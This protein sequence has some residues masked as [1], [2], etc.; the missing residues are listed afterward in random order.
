MTCKHV[1]GLLDAGP[2]ADYPGG[3]LDAAWRH[4]RHCGRCGRA[5]MAATRL[6]ADLAALP[7]PTPP[8][9]LTAAVLAR[10]AQSAAPHSD[11][12]ATAMT[13]PRSNRSDWPAGITAIGALAGGVA[14]LLSIDANSA[15]LGILS[16]TVGR[17]EGGL[18][19]APSTTMEAL[20]LAA[21]LLLYLV[22]LFAPLRSSSVPPAISRNR[23]TPRCC[24]TMAR[25]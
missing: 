4:A 11:R 8:R 21:G 2:F 13:R 3:H 9:D 16:P 19:A 20:L 22:G 12:A 10:C 6:G 14:L 15:P 18:I 1:L 23:S 5:L 25:R 24:V 7:Q 17:L